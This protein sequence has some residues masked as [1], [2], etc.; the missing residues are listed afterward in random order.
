MVFDK[1]CEEFLP[2]SFP[3]SLP[4]LPFVVAR[5]RFSGEEDAWLPIAWELWNINLWEIHSDLALVCFFSFSVFDHFFLH[6]SNELNPNS[7]V[8]MFYSPTGCVICVFSSYN[9]ASTRVLNIVCLLTWSQ[10]DQYRKY[11]LSRQHNFINQ[12]SSC[13]SGA[14]LHK[15]AFYNSLQL[16][17]SAIL[18]SLHCPGN[19][20]LHSIWGAYCRPQELRV[21][22]GEG[23]VLI[24]NVW[25]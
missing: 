4:S 21:L 18:H 17:I 25:G 23:N 2:L 12:T 1:F 14:Q 5:R 22:S 6:I 15:K 3:F 24:V 10:R 13:V 11:M 8:R 20:S 7:C 16:L 9:N 19:R